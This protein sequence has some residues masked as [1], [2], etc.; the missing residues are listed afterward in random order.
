MVS[1]LA[2]GLSGLGSSSGREH[3][4]V[5]LG[6]TLPS[7]NA[8]LPQDEQ[9]GSDEFNAGVTLL[10]TSIPCMLQKPELSA[11]LVCRINLYLPHCN[12]S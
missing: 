2:A 4:V 6:K 12:T 7:Q 8:S 11:G 10:W 5:F 9:M 3:C 1:A